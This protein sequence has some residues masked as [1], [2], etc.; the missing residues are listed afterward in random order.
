[1]LALDLKRVAAFV[2]EADTEELLDRVTVYRVGMEPVA[3]DLMEAELD[4]RG[5]TRSD[6]ADHH[7]ERRQRAILLPDGSALRCNFCVRP[8]VVRR[9]GWHRAFGVLPVFPLVFARCE[10]HEK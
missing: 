8:A 1:M 2:R 3:L 10:K 9:W 6:I 5:V 7:I 4:R